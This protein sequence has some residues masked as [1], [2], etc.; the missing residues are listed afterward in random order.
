MNYWEQFK[1]SL[2][3]LVAGL[4]AGL[5]FAHI[6][7][8]NPDTP[9]PVSAQYDSLEREKI[10]YMQKAAAER[11][12]KDSAIAR[13][14]H[15]TDSLTSLKSKYAGIQKRK[16]DDPDLRAA[17]VPALDKFWTKLDSAR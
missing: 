6:K 13:A 7:R 10:H 9:G 17:S 14:D 5:V 4:V 3:W 1:I 2:F 16:A 11:R 8:D 15:Y 12:A